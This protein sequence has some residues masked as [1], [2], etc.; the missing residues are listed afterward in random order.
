ML[1]REQG[2]FSLC[3]HD[4]NKRFLEA[5]NVE[6]HAVFNCNLCHGSVL[7][8]V[9]AYLGLSVYFFV[10]RTLSRRIG[11]RMELSTHTGLISEVYHALLT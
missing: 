6:N 7:F 2:S 8:L 11:Q 9:F 5:K 3:F 4:S 10:S 1:H